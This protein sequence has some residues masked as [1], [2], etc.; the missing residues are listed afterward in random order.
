M[1]TTD[2]IMSIYPG[3]VD[4]ILSGRKTI[5]LRRRIPNL[6]LGTS[7]WIYAT[8]PTSAV[9]CRATI[10]GLTRGKPRSIWKKHRDATAIDF[11]TFSA[12]F[13]GAEEAVAI[14]LAA[15][16]PVGPIT[17]ERLREVRGCFH[18]PQVA[19]LLSA[20]EVEEL[21]KVANLL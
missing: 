6:P 19:T 13:D 21:R 2:A 17:I 16:E 3:Y 14:L 1:S 12:Y 4:A 7:L 9:V 8:R 20:A 18:P 15:V 10:Q 11:A 5:E